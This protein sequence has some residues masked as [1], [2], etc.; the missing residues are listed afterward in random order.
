MNFTALQVKT[1]YSILNSLNDIKKLVALAKNYGYE[2]LAI[3]DDGNMFG[4][5][6][7]YLECNKN[8]IKPIIGVDLLIGEGHILLYA[9]NN[10]GYKNIIKLS[11][12][13]SDRL[14]T[15]EDLERYRDNLILV[16]PFSFYNDRVFNIYDDKFIGYTT[17]SEKE[18]IES[19]KVFIND[20]SYLYKDD[21]IYL[22]YA[23]MIKEGKIVGEYEI[24]TNKNRYLY[25]KE[26]ILNIASSED[27]KNMEYIV[28]SC[29][30]TIEYTAGLLPIY[31]KDIDSFKYLHDMSL[32]G[33]N[34]RM[35]GNVPKEYHER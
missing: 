2:S 16:M 20:V 5:M 21:A 3:T 27:I 7:F 24:D 10:L 8:N 29:N 19:K 15:I 18:K 32:K 14:L 9:K 28:E 25:T 17:S 33:L 31:N 1:S 12:I 23:N 22:D 26:E 13:V 34:K 6:E 30:V 4:V 11:T 35:N